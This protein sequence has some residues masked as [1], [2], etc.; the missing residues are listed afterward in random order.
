M[1]AVVKVQQSAKSVKKVPKVQRECK[2][3][4]IR[5]TTLFLGM[6]QKNNDHWS[7][8]RVYI[9]LLAIWVCILVA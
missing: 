8:K 7:E 3:S 9:A 1:R 4:T 2:I 6:H 5:C